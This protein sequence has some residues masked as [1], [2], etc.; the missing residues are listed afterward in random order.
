MRESTWRLLLA[1]F[2]RACR[3]PAYRVLLAE[4]G[5][6]PD[7]ITEPKDFLQLPI[8]DKHNTFERFAV[9]ELCVDGTPGDVASV[10]TS[11]GHSGV[12]AFGLYSRQEAKAAEERLD[13][14]FDGLFKVQ[15][16]KTLMINCLPMGVRVPTRACTIGDTSVRAD[17]ALGQIRGFA[18]YFEQIVLLGETAFVKHLLELGI[19][20]G[21]DW[22]AMTVHVIVGEEPM[23]ENAR[24]YLQALLAIDPRRPETGKVISSMGVGELGL[25][26]FYEDPPRRPAARSATASSR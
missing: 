7:D 2:H 26:L 20:Q 9:H 14:V 4:T 16:R 19:K 21:V 18:R 11:S 8:L 5:V 25:H 13:A 10:L 3:T 22:S 15:S 17:M 6:S 23:A 24:G 1:A 12:F